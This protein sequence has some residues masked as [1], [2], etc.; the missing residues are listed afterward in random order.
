MDKN[1]CKNE[2][3]VK[4]IDKPS[5]GTGQLLKFFCFPSE[6]GSNLKGLNLLPMGCKFYLKEKTPFLK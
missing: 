5:Y 3:M 4:E 2:Q 6:K 1:L